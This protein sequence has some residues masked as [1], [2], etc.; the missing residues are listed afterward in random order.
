MRASRISARCAARLFSFS[1]L[2]FL[3]CGY[4]ELIL[5][6]ARTPE[7]QG[8]RTPLR[9]VRPSCLS[10]VLSVL[11]DE[12]RQRS[13]FVARLAVTDSS[14]GTAS[15]LR[16]THRHVGHRDGHVLAQPCQRPHASRRPAHY[17]ANVGHRNEEA[18]PS[19][20]GRRRLHLRRLASRRAFRVRAP[21]SPASCARRRW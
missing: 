16:G 5:R 3:S 9:G 12:R 14:A 6:L 13:A 18:A 21:T 11:P 7:S 2:F 17:R 10:G 15:P 19:V 1:G 4:R 8:Y 20:K